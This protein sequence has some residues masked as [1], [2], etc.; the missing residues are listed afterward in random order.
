LI[1]YHLHFK[2]KVA[3]GDVKEEHMPDALHRQEMHSDTVS[4]FKQNFTNDETLRDDI[5][6]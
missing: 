4:I 1:E 2:V 3:I 6:G 5:A